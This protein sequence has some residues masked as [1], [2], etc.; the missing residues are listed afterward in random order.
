MSFWAKPCE[1]AHTLRP[2]GIDQD[3]E[4]LRLHQNGSVVDECDAKLAASYARGWR[5]GGCLL[6]PVP[7]PTRSAW[8][9]SSEGVLKLIFRCAFVV[10]EMLP[11]EVIAHGSVIRRRH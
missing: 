9:L 5:V 4:T 2:H 3:V 11:I 8:L 10:E 7:V 1:R 6:P